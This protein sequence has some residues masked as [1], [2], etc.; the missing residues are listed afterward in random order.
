M[1][2]GL[3]VSHVLQGARARLRHYY[4]QRL[5]QR[6]FWRSVLG[7]KWSLVKSMRDLFASLA[8]ARGG[9]WEGPATAASFIEGMEL[10]LRSFQ[11]PTLFLISEADLTAREFLDLCRASDSWKSLVS[12]PSVRFTQLSGT[13]HTF[14]R[15]QALDRAN[16]ECRR[17]LQ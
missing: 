2:C 6:S 9:P 13:D 4:L 1:R 11:G 15:R 10:G 7:G 3:R 12:R 17:W 5:F 16:E 14:S 8:Q